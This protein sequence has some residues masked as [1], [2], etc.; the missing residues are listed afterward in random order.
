MGK[1]PVAMVFAKAKRC[2]RAGSQFRENFAFLRFRTAAQHGL[3]CQHRAN[4]GCRQ[5]VAPHLLDY[6]YNLTQ[7]QP[8]T[9]ISV[10]N[11]NTQPPKLS[12]F[13]PDIGVVPG[14]FFKQRAHLFDRRLIAAETRRN[15]Y[16]LSL[17]FAQPDAG[18]LG[19]IYKS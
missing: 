19:R 9:A 10:G 5:Q 12:Y 7:T 17:F 11:A 13:L 3:C 1:V 6:R 2:R 8:D 4:I 14:V 15:I 16:K 18:R